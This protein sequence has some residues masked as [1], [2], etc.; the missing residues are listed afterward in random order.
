MTPAERYLDLCRLYCE[1]VAMHGETPVR[2]GNRSS[3][4]NHGWSPRPPEYPYVS[5]L[6]ELQEAFRKWK[7]IR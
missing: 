6:K 1:R 5:R 3:S 2:K 7:G 4:T